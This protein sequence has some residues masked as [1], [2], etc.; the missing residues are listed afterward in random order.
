[1]GAAVSEAFILV[2]MVAAMLVC[3]LIAS[4]ELL[5]LLILWVCP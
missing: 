3:V 2:L 5:A 4:P 1:M